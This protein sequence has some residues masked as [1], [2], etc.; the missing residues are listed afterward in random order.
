MLR[1]CAMGAALAWAA[2]AVVCLIGVLTLFV[3]LQHC[4]A[5][6]GRDPVSSSFCFVA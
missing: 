1:F 3:V 2:V 4:M 5:S 6:R